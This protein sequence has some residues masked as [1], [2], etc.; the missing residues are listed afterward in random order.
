MNESFLQLKGHSA[1]YQG[2]KQLMF[3]CVI[4]CYQRMLQT[5]PPH[6]APGIDP[7]YKF[8]ICL[9]TFELNI[10][11]FKSNDNQGPIDLTE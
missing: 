5:L 9:S 8:K 4:M 3:D 6:H 7:I 10:Q 11:S 2:M 1:H